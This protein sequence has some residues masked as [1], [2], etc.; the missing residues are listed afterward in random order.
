MADPVSIIAGS[1]AVAWITGVIG[2][3]VLGGLTTI[4]ELTV[5]VVP[6][7]LSVITYLRKKTVVKK[8]SNVLLTYT[9]GKF[10]HSKA[11]KEIHTLVSK[12]FSRHTK[13]E[14]LKIYKFY[15]T[16]EDLFY[17]V[18]FNDAYW[19]KKKEEL[20]MNP[21][22]M[23]SYLIKKLY[24]D[25]IFKIIVVKLYNRTPPE[26]EEKVLYNDLIESYMADDITEESLHQFLEYLEIEA[27]KQY[28]ANRNVYDNDFETEKKYI[29]DIITKA[30]SRKLGKKLRNA[31]NGIIETV[32]EQVNPME[33]DMELDQIDTMISDTN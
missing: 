15:K 33:R 24:I 8:L 4:G 2:T 31:N 1:S 5:S 10:G 12:L 30:N 17:K 21:E 28:E 29:V 25:R 32:Q 26:E 9:T 20:I 11:L 23:K 19:E 22:K 14:V 16:L 18:Q 13:T 27:D 7:G 3:P 6:L